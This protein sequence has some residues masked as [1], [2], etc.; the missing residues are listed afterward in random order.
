[1]L[2]YALTIVKIKSNPV[3]ENLQILKQ[4][5]SSMSIRSIDSV[6]ILQGPLTH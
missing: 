1:M 5:A 4:K 2:L 3:N 6:A